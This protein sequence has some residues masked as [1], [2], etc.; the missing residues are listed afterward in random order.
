MLPPFPRHNRPRGPG[1]TG[2]R[3]RVLSAWRG[4][5]L[6]P[7]EKARR[8]SARST[9]DVM[10]KVLSELRIDK[11]QAEA[12]IVKVWNHMLDPNIT[13]HAQ[14]TGIRKGTVFVSV[15]SNVWLA[16]LVR[17]RRKEILER[18]QHCFGS[19]LVARLS[20]RVG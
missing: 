14:P 10:P 15:D 8:I 16:E 9:A 4:L 7:A 20:F 3:D 19:E 2:A 1:K 17:Y 5:N 12:E 13:K 11:R 6:A 18:L